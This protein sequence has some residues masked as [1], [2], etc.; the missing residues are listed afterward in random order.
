MPEP[1]KIT[2]LTL[3]IFSCINIFAQE[4][5]TVITGHVSDSEGA[6]LALV[7]I[8]IIGEPY[9]TYSADDGF[10]SF[11]IPANNNIYTLSYSIIG[12]HSKD[13]TFKALNDTIIIDISLETD[14]TRLQDVTIREL[15][16]REAPSL[17]NIPVRDINLM[18]AAAGSIEKM[19]ISLPGVNSN[20]ELSSQ[21]S[22]R[23]GNYDENLVYVN[24]IEIYHPVLIKSGRQE[25][26]SFLNPDLI[27]NVKFSA[28]GF[29]ASYGDR[30]SSVLDIKYKDPVESNGS[31]SIGLIT[32][33]A[34]IEGISKNGRFSYLAGTR[35][36][37]NRFLL[38]TLDTRANYRPVFNDFQTLLKY[39]LKNNSE[40]SL[41][42][43]YSSN[44]YSFTPV[45]QRSTFGN[46][47][48]AYQLYVVYAGS[49]TDRFRSN[50]IA[51]SWDLNP[52]RAFSNRFI[53]HYYH[54]LEKETYDIRGSY[55]LNMLDKNLGSENF[56]DSIMNVG[57][58]SWLDHARNILNIKVYTL[59][60]KGRWQHSDNILSWGIK[61][62]TESATDHIREWQRIDSAGYTIPYS[63]E[64]LSLSKLTISDTS[65]LTSKAEAYLIDNYT[66]NPGN[67]QIILSGGA[68]F[69][70]WAFS[71][72]LLFSPRLSVSWRLPDNNLSL[73]L[74]SGIYYQP[75]F[76]REMKY[77]D[78]SINYK[79]KTQKSQHMVLGLDYN[80]SAGIRPL[81]LTAEVYYKKLDDI[82][83]Y[84]YDNVRIIYSAENNA[85]AYISGIDL[86][87]N[88]EFV[89]N[90]ES[91]ISLSLMQAKYD[92]IGDN[93]GY[94]PSP[95]DVRFS[96]NIFFQDYFP[97][98]P[99]YRAHINLHYSTGMPLSS[100]LSDNYENYNRMPSYRRVD[101]GFTRVFRNE[102]S[103]SDANFLSFFDEIIAGIEVFN[104]LD[105]RNTISYHWLSTVNNLSGETRQFA[106]PN[107]LTGRALNIKLM[108]KF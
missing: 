63:H 88:G 9:G 40:L 32:S 37:T 78:G 104:L 8:G 79:I 89:K 67:H 23:G 95:S 66:F 62:N 51:L 2:V 30:M 75:P 12:F 53:A 90:A 58:G 22:V 15:S 27:D 83:P 13:T 38:Q 50:N 92:I 4:D 44:T 33:T 87:I 52:S 105:I 81:K 102:Y 10:Y 64:M 21:Y 72:E 69:T 65:L 91:W 19:L 85:S 61:Y 96:T 31:I 35:Y 98:N 36:K 26:L 20:N 43:G 1:A 47:S 77:P 84:K 6:A 101:I 94:F 107:Y 68:R 11:S 55:A 45:S 86:R 82:I 57:I 73:Y 14:I 7:N 80:F 103:M 5:L 25:G 100:P 93:T 24:D 59:S 70:Y 16:Y 49:E 71:T 28:G 74:S 54:S 60:Y 42:Y 48:E 76:Y 41:L 3:L 34:H 18:P 29:N 17:R 99:G 108:C 46:I 97:S 56:G 39:R 106:I